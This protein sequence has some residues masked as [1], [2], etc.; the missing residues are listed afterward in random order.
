MSDDLGEY[1]LKVFELA[2]E[3][4]Y[5]EI[6]LISKKAYKKSKSNVPLEI[7]VDSIANAIAIG[8]DIPYEPKFFKKLKLENYSVGTHLKLERSVDENKIK[9]I[10]KYQP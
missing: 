5:N 2:K 6:I 9:E 1:L 8:K 7:A 10:I 4:K 3:K